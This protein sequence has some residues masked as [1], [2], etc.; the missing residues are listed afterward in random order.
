[1]TNLNVTPN[2]NTTI[3]P[4]PVSKLEQKLV[5]WI[6][7]VEACNS[8]FF[9]ITSV[10]G[11]MYYLA[12]KKTTEILSCEMLTD[13]GGG[14]ERTFSYCKERNQQNADI[15]P[16]SVIVKNEDKLITN[17]NGCIF[18][19]GFKESCE[20]N[21]KLMVLSFKTP[22]SYLIIM[23]SNT[24]AVKVLYAW[25]SQQ[26]DPIQACLN[27]LYASAPWRKEVV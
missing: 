27:A 4:A 2:T 11:K 9:A 17:H 5:D 25:D 1:M 12:G 8:D 22:Y 26:N 16:I 24:A 23:A 19:F 20:S 7:K 3:S 18:G 6:E 15:T 13:T 10:K 21:T 14:L